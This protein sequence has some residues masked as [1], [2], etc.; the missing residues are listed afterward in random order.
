MAHI[1]NFKSPS[2]GKA[3]SQ[4]S[5]AIA[6]FDIENEMAAEDSDYLTNT[7]PSNNWA[8]RYPRSLSTM[9]AASRCSFQTCGD[10]QEQPKLKLVGRTDMILSG[11]RATKMQSL[12]NGSGVKIATGGIGG[13]Y[14]HGANLLPTILKC[15]AIDLIS[16]HR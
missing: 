3:W 6:A 1:L 12:I 15:S 2:S 8:C 10:V 7:E 4:W 11:D 5:E 14:S 9:R 16:I 13:D